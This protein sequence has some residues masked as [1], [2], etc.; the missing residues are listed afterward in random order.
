MSLVIPISTLRILILPKSTLGAPDLNLS[1]SGLTQIN[2]E[3][4]DLT[5]VHPKGLMLS[6]V[7][8]GEVACLAPVEGPEQG[9]EAEGEAGFHTQPLLWAQVMTRPKEA[10]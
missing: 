8:E 10:L 1:G 3:S 6:G 2:L 9:G 5:Q 4:L 7:E